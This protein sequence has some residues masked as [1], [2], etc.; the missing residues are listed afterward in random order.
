MD[1]LDRFDMVDRVTVVDIEDRVNRAAMEM[2][3]I[4]LLYN[5]VEN[6]R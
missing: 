4:V 1:L 6:T 2:M 5:N 3:M